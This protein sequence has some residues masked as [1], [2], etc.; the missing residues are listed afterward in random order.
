MCN[1]YRINQMKHKLHEYTYYLISV[2]SRVFAVFP[3]HYN[4]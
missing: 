1:S 3:N 2:H 4:R